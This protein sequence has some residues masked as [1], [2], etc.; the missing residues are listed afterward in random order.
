MTPMSMRMAT[1]DD[2][3]AILGIYAPYILDTAITFEAEAPP[4]EDFRRRIAAVLRRYPY[5]VGTV[6]GVVIGYAY[7]HEQRE[8]A[9]YRWNAELS[10]YLD[11]DRVGLGMGGRL[12]AALLDILVLQNVRNVYGIVTAPNP[13]SERLHE[14]FGF[15][16][17][18]TWRRT[19]YK[20]GSWHDVIWFEKRLGDDD[21]GEPPPVIPVGELSADALAA[22][23]AGGGAAGL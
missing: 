22:I 1:S 17:A 19:G 3:E 2:A 14:R 12:F 15:T 5:L 11:R 16:R 20:H 9:A 7:A 13:R 21:G 6:D 18:G 23:L 4:L 8:R 10:L